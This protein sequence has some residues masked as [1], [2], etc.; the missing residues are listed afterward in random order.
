MSLQVAGRCDRALGDLA[1]RRRYDGLDDRRSELGL[2][3]ENI[4]EF[5]VEAPGPGLATRRAVDQP[6]GELQPLSVAADAA[7]EHGG[8]TEPLGDRLWCPAPCL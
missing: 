2:H 4:V 1:P 7:F 6:R 8:H 3:G 5:A